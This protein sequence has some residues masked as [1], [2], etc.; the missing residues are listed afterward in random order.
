MDTGHLDDTTLLHYQQNKLDASTRAAVAA[1]VWSC[2][3]CD[4][5]LIALSPDPGLEAVVRAVVQEEYEAETLPA[6]PGYQVL[7]LIKTGGMGAV[8][9]THDPVFG[10]E[11]VLKVPRAGRRNAEYAARFQREAV[12]MGQLQHPGIPP[13]HAF[14]FLTDGRPFLVMKR[15]QGPTLARL[16]TG[17]SD[18]LAELPRFLDLFGR[19][20]EAVAHAHGRGVIH[21]DLKP[22][23][24]MVG[25]SD[26]IQVMDWGLAKNLD[27]PDIPA[28]DDSAAETARPAGLTHTGDLLGTPAYMSP[29]QARGQELDARA[30]VF[31]LGAILCHILTG[32]PP[33]TAESAR[34]AA[35]QARAADLGPAFARLEQSGADSEL[36]ALAKACLALLPADR[37]GNSAAVAERVTAYQRGLQEK[38]RLAGEEQAR[39]EARVEEEKHTREE[40]QKRARAEKRLRRTIVVAAAVMLALLGG[41]FGVVLWRQQVESDKRA[42]SA[43]R[44]SKARGAAAQSLDQAEADLRGERRAAARLALEQAKSWLPEA[45]DDELQERNDE[46]AADLHFAETLDG[47]AQR[48]IGLYE[49]RTDTQSYTKALDAAFRARG[50]DLSAAEAEVLAGRIQR[51]PA[52]EVIVRALDDWATASEQPKERQRVLK[53]VQLAD[54]DKSGWRDRVRSPEAFLDKNV[55][56]DLAKEAEKGK[57]APYLVVLLNERLRAAKGDNLPLLRQAQQFNPRDFWINFF[58]GS[59]LLGAQATSRGHQEI[60]QKALAAKNRFV[61]GEAAGYLHAAIVARPDSSYARNNHGIALQSLG[62]I[63]GAIAA[64]EEVTKLA[65][66]FPV[67]YVN[68]AQALKLKGDK[69]L[70]PQARAACLAALRLDKNHASAHHN[71]SAILLDLGDIQGAIAEANAAI[72]SSPRFAPAHLNLAFALRADKQGEAALAAARDACKADGKLPLAYFVLGT[73]LEDKHDLPGACAAY[74]TVI[75]LD[76]QH[77]PAYHLLGLVRVKLK[78]TDMAIAAYRACIALDRNNATV[79]NDLGIALDKMRKTDE[80]IAT[81][82]AALTIDDNYADAHSNLGS[83]LERKGLLEK[84]LFHCQKAVDLA[85]NNARAHNNL[86]LVW[87]ALKKFENAVASLRTATRIDRNY[88]RGWINLGVVLETQGAVDEAISAYEKVIEIDPEDGAAHSSM[89]G[90]LARQGKLEKAL[91]HANKA[92]ALLPYRAEVH[93]NRGTVLG[94]AKQFDEAVASFHRSIELGP[95]NALTHAS[96]AEVLLAQGMIKESITACEKAIAIDATCGPAYFHRGNI[97]FLRNELPEA[98]LDYE[99]ACKLDENRVEALVNL[100]IVLKRLGD[101]NGAVSAYEKALLKTPSDHELLYNLGV[102]LH[103]QGKLDDAI[104]ANKKAIV[105]APTNPKLQHNLGMCHRDRG[106]F[107]EAEA[108]LRQAVKLEEGYAFAHCNLGS[109]LLQQGKFAE[110]LARLKRGHELGSRLPNWRFDSSGSVK[111]CERL[112]ELEKHLTALRKGSWTPRNREERLEMARVCQCKSMNALAAKLY[113]EALEGA[114]APREKDRQSAV[115]SAVLAGTGQG[116]DGAEL[117]DQG[118]IRQRKQALEW[119]AKELEVL[120]NAVRGP[121]KKPNYTAARQLRLW[122]QDLRLEGVRAR[123]ALDSLPATERSAWQQFWTKVE[124]VRKETEASK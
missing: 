13:V 105:L 76:P 63:G 25:E 62:D 33:Y 53:V 10:R 107:N 68:L 103:A 3:A 79:R 47:H 64:F 84:A 49:S 36:I 110:A 34:V 96:L 60:T 92:V 26:E 32:G 30:D 122:Q 98:R 108:A 46:L 73:V 57:D 90:L 40:A 51:S 39:T 78:Q 121:G 86:A 89:G 44:R 41:V 55:M 61:L 69:S 2:A 70:L 109:I 80:A 119:L 59:E 97:H 6:V 106:Q 114:P 102:A 117:D 100:G 22:S 116:V 54:L 24:V 67:G 15:V 52:R 27:E 20:A 23:N 75:G 111:E 17:R 66:E 19:L 88:L 81:F 43:A 50:L 82:R 38:L 95:M 115:W 74:E 120:A 8:Y 11:V 104:T 31:S 16:L 124:S 21:R 93:A 45:E 87:Y 9:R 83:A 18:G 85:P 118:R 77:A 5:R 91:F 29:E 42:E 71:L 1:H 99:K 65:P 14:G 28:A 35:D 58:L 123:S 94:L 112:I 113:A 72:R 12:L 37:P 4:R 7:E 101:L 56:E 48:R